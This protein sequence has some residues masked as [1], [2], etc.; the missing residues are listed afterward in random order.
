MKT[1][2]FGECAHFAKYLKELH[3]FD[4]TYVYSIQFN[5]AEGSYCAHVSWQMFRQ[6]VPAHCKVGVHYREDLRSVHFDYY[7]GRAR[8]TALL[9]DYDMVSDEVDRGKT[10]KQLYAEWIERSDWPYGT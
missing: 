2:P 6:V 5:P 1:F 3:A 7:D 10:I 9:N 8:F 4:E